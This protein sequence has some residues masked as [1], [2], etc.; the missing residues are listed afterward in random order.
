MRGYLNRRKCCDPRERFPGPVKPWWVCVTNVLGGSVTLVRHAASKGVTG[1]DNSNKLAQR[2]FCDTSAGVNQGARKLFSRNCTYISK[3]RAKLKIALEA[4][5]TFRA[6][7]S[8]SLVCAFFTHSRASARLRP[9]GSCLSP[10]G[11]AV[12][13]LSAESRRRQ[14]T[15]P[16]GRSEF[17]PSCGREAP[18]ARQGSLGRR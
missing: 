15:R 6:Y 7:E 14:E 18:A 13:R 16:K 1:C 9:P 12:S 17:P 5:F 4:V 10:S 11:T 2:L 3:C 8:F